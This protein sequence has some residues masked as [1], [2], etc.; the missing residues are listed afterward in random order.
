MSYAGE[1][2][3]S[4]VKKQKNKA[5]RQGEKIKSSKGK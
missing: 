2:V 5:A 4:P 1:E 3:Q